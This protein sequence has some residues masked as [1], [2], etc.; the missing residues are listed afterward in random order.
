MELDGVDDEFGRGFGR[1][2]EL[3]LGVKLFEDVVLECASECV[4]WDV[5]LFGHGEVHRPDDGCGCVDGLGDGHLVDGDVG[6]EA[7]HIFDGVDSDAALADFAQAEDIVGISAHECWEVK[8]GG[9]PGVGSGLCFG[10]GE[11]VLESFVGVVGRAEPGELAHGPEACA[12]A[13]GE[14]ASG[15]GELA[16]VVD[17]SV[18][19]LEGGGEVVGCVGG[20]EDEPGDGD[21]VGVDFSGLGINAG[22]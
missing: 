22:A 21:S 19:V 15:V 20:V 2:D 12:V 11:D 3:V 14:E 10:L 7:V 18:V 16:G 9:E 4:P 17:V 13:L 6:V 5:A 8:G 1:I